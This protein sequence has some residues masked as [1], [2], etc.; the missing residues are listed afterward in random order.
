M[1]YLIIL[2]TIGILNALFL[3]WQY[4][5][6][7]SN[8]TKMFCFL[9]EDCSKVVGSE[10]GS[11]LGLKNEL[12]GITYYFAIVAYGV[13]SQFSLMPYF[14]TTIILVVGAGATAFSIYLL[15][16]QAYV[17]KTFCSWCLIAILVNFLIFAN[18]FIN[19]GLI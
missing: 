17:L 14:L 12:I 15:Y 13:L 3:N 6:F 18:L 16:L 9:G 1:I 8:G 10:Y 4:K 5:R 19:S 11:H 2:S 7:V